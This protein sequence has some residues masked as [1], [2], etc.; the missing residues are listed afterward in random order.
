MN[1][2]VDVVIYVESMKQYIFGYEDYIQMLDEFGIQDR[3]KFESLL[4]D[5]IEAMSM[6]NYLE[7]D[8]P[9]LSFDQFDD[10]M[11]FAVADYHLECL[12]ENGMIESYI[13]EDN[14]EIFYRVTEKAQT[15]TLINNIN[16][17]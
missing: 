10:S 6:E 3:N 8:N 17:N 2:P 14:M 5:N 12:Q 7:R 1:K 11:K 13:D 15:Q 4:L 16:Y 9:E